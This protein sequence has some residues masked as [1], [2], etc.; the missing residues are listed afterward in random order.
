[1]AR[2][3]GELEPQDS[4]SPGA[5]LR[6]ARKAAG[7]TSLTE[8]ADLLHRSKGSLSGIELGKM[9]PSEQLVRLYETTLGLEEGSLISL[10]QEKLQPSRGNWTNGNWS[11][12]MAKNE[13]EQKVPTLGET[14]DAILAFSGLSLEDQRTVSFQIIEA[15]VQAIHDKQNPQ[16]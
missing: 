13:S 10:Y 8:F 11:R 3:R 12:R 9:K 7:F 4:N 16:V 5:K 14:I 1:M 15:V 2:G 6:V